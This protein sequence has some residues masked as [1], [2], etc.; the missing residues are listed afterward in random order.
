MTQD[1]AVFG[2]IFPDL[3]SSCFFLIADDFAPSSFSMRAVACPL[4]YR[5]T[6]ANDPPHTA[7]WMLDL[8]VSDK[9]VLPRIDLNSFHA[10]NPWAHL[11]FNRQ[12]KI[13]IL[14]NSRSLESDVRNLTANPAAYAHQNKL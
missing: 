1:K 13:T 7:L 2:S 14:E 12:A 10:E 9:A 11:R 6:I 3:N 4:D 8:K 5:L